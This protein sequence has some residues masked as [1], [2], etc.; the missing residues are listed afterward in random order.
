M[1]I[2]SGAIDTAV[3]Q[4][5][6]TD[7]TLKGFMPDGVFFDLAPPA[8]KRYV[9]LSVVDAFDARRFDGRS[10]ESIR[11]MVKAVGHSGVTTAATDVRNAA[12]RIDA[13]LDPQPP[14][15][16]VAL[17]IAGY[18]LMAS[19]RDLELPRI[20]HTEPDAVDPTIRFFHRGGHYLIVAS[21]MP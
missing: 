11:Y 1:P 5:L 14:D 20:R 3:L 4:R 18:E 8:S 19:F 15:P 9:L 21:T 6:S 16:P 10:H 13:L 7:A 2:D 17:T 12:A